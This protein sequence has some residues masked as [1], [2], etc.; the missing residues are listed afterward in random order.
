MTIIAIDPGA[1]GGIAFSHNSGSV[2]S[3]NMP[4][5]VRD[6]VDLLRD[7]GSEGAEHVTVYLEKVGGY[8]GGAGA[9]GS[10]MFSF[11]KNVGIVEGIIATLGYRL[12]SPTPQVWQKAL[13]LGNSK[14]HAS[15]TAWKNHLK[16]RA[17]QLYPQTKVTLATADALLIHH[18]AK[19]GMLK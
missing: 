14:S 3:H 18:A 7:A 16:N 8:V 13:S 2:A 1:S 15:K 6:L 5:T 9:P 10:A 11:G 19:E 12:I 4:D 17:Q